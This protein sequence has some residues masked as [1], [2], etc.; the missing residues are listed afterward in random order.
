MVAHFDVIND[1]VR[2]FLTRG[3]ITVRRSLV[4]ETANA[5][6]GQ[7]MVEPRTRAAQTTAH[8]LCRQHAWIRV[9]GLVTDVLRVMPQPS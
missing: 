3:V 5:R 6:L 9:T 8:P 1:G 4:R 2:G 7:R